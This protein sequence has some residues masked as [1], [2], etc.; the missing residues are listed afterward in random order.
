MT[1]LLIAGTEVVLPKNFTCTVK[2]ENPFFTKSGEYTYDVTLRLDNSVNRTLYGFVHRLNKKEQVATGRQAVL[3]AGGH[4]YTRGTEVITGWT[5]DTVTLQIVS[6]ESEL[7]F[8]IG[9]EQKVE[10]LELGNIDAL[11]DYQTAGLVYP[12]TDFCL[13]PVRDSEGNLWNETFKQLTAPQPGLPVLVPVDRR[14]VVAQPFLCAMVRRIIEALGYTIDTDQLAQTQF[15]YLFLVNTRRT[16]QYAR[17]LPGWT[18]KDFL[19][20]VERLTGCVFVTDNTSRRCS[21]L[22]KTT[23]YQQSRVLTLRNVVDQ[24]QVEVEDEEGREAEFSTSNV[25]YD[26]PSHRW[27]KLMRLPDGLLEEAFIV[28][29]P[30]GTAILEAEKDYTVIMRDVMTQRLYVWQHY[31]ERKV[32]VAHA[33]AWDSYATLPAGDVLVEVDEFRDLRR[34]G[35]ESELTLAITP[36]PMVNIGYGYEII[37]LGTTDGY[38]EYQITE[39]Q[40]NIDTSGSGTDG[41]IGD[42]A[43]VIRDYSKTEEKKGSLYCAFFAGDTAS[44]GTAIVYTDGPHLRM[45]SPAL[46][47]LMP[48]LKLRTESLRLQDM[49][50]D[51]F[52]GGYR[53][54]TRH[55]V[56]VETFDPNVI[57]VRQVYVVG[58]RRY[59]VRDV[60]ETVTAEGRQPRWKASLYPI[61]MSDVA[62][63]RRW[64]LTNGVWDDGGVWLDDGRWKDG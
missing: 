41:V 62:A 36:A 37:D 28:D 43:S 61:E 49:N 48:F 22:M 52:Q 55:R 42:I 30:D 63:D 53:T 26:L 14:D 1:Q 13:A 40:I 11:P 25:V 38:N 9:Q 3:V 17:M 32:K 56:T 2:R 33:M 24:Y 10:E 59:V 31:D 39:E 60:E 50:D 21:I 12:D 64:V 4:V 27:E 16:T 8:F 18:V 5:Q 20:E 23:Y 15:R 19:T 45:V 57:D 54:D 51:H 47:E 7:N 44:N 29:Y 34:E 46:T 58:N 6:G 35:V